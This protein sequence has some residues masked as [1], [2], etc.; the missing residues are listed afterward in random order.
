M[1]E[2][3]QRGADTLKNPELELAKK[4]EGTETSCR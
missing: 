2:T 1:N 4:T 3:T